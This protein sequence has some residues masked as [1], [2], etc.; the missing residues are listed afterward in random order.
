MKHR[1][2]AG[3]YRP[4]TIML[5]GAAQYAGKG[6]EDPQ[7]YGAGKDDVFDRPSA[8]SASRRAPAEPSIRAQ[9]PPSSTPTLNISR[10]LG[11]VLGLLSPRCACRRP[12]A[13][14]SARRARRLA[15]A[16]LAYSNIVFAGAILLW[17]FK[18]LAMRIARTAT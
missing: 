15:D 3:D 13:L 17:V 1:P 16:A 2:G 9:G 8:A 6:L 4:A 18:T 10:G 14:S 11:W 12:C 7:H 5:P